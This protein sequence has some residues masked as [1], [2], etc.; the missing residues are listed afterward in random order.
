MRERIRNGAAIVILA[1]CLALA[2]PTFF[3][4]QQITAFKFGYEGADLVVTWVD[5]DN[6]YQSDVAP[7]MVVSQF[8]RTPIEDI[9]PQQLERF[10]Q[11]YYKQV[12]FPNPTWGTM[13]WSM[14]EEVGTPSDS[15]FFIGLGLLF[16]IAIWVRRGQAGEAL[17]PLAIPLAVA[18]VT[19]LILSPAWPFLTWPLIAVG[20]LLSTLGLL[21]LADG[22]LERIPRRSL[23]LGAAA[24]AIAAAIGCVAVA[25]GELPPASSYVPGERGVTMPG[26][27][28]G[29]ATAVTLVPAAMLLIAG[30]ARSRA[31]TPMLLAA[32]TPVLIA[33][34]HGF[35]YMGIG[36]TIPLLWLLVVA[37][38]LQ[39]NARAEILRAQRD[40]V[41]AAAE[42]ERARLAADLH[43]GALQEMTVLVRELDD[44]GDERSADLARS[45]AERMREVCGDL[46]LPILDELGA[47]A[48]LE[49]LV[50]RVGEASGGQ[51][52]LERDDGVRPP[53]DVELAVFRV[54][55]EALS[56]AVA[57]GAPPIVVRYAAAA[58]RASLSVTDQGTG[59]ESNAASKAARSG[60]YGLLN[61]RQRADQIGGKIDVRR[62]P[63]GGTTIGLSWSSP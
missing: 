24:V 61:M 46:R 52:R 12:G 55:Q 21:V 32:V 57:H 53:A 47:G 28:A 19:S 39:T 13:E 18:S 23:R 6:P 27:P 62:P 40:N 7:G 5:P 48:A 29:F 51:V 59:I 56:N 10:I 36:L 33:T 2:I 42:R 41:V 50:D 58:N 43:D 3:A 1:V 38:V 17:R 15:V 54:A 45:V 11:G 31:R 63:N 37:F 49:W 16:G 30:D 44:R 60:H 35:A 34:T 22:F 26:L 25:L 14:P 4:V 8:D 9:P 20:L